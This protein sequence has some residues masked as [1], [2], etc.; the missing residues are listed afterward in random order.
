[1]AKKEFY[2][3]VG[4]YPK[5]NPQYA[6]KKAAE[7]QEKKIDGVQIREDE[8]TLDV[9]VGP[10]ETHEQTSAIV[11]ILA[12]LGIKAS[13]SSPKKVKAQNE[14]DTKAQG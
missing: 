8:N 14:A 12:D 2:A 4:A 1:M 7:L 11:S 9:V 13:I 10:F 3:I 5:N 6:Q